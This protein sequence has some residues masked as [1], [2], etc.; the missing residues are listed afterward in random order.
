MI[1]STFI[2]CAVYA[3][4]TS[5]TPSTPAVISIPIKKA[6]SANTNIQFNIINIQNPSQ[7]GVPIGITLKLATP[8]Y[9]S[10]TNNLCAYYKSTTYLSFNTAVGVPGY[11][12][13]GTHSFNPN[14]I[15]AKN[16]V[17][18]ISASYS[19][20]V[21]D[22]IKVK[23]YP[24]VPIPATC[25]I[26]SGN[27]YCYSYPSINTIVIKATVAINSP[28]IFTLTGMTNP[29]QYYYPSNPLDT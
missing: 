27:G 26:S 17:H 3:G 13:T 2:T 23:Y 15:S 6:I 1:S 29:H 11:V 5:T 21:G 8:C 12:Y 7:S 24:Q 25:Q 10:D 9:F 16:T 22:F 4:S 28:Y 19:L 20:A 18:T 14:I